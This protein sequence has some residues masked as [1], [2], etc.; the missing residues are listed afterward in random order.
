MVDLT[1]QQWNRLKP[2]LVFRF[3]FGV[4]SKDVYIPQSAVAND[5]LHP[6]YKFGFQNVIQVQF[7]HEAYQFVAQQN[8]YFSNTSNAAYLDQVMTYL[9]DFGDVKYRTL[10]G[11]YDNINYAMANKLVDEQNGLPAR[12]GGIFLN[13]KLVNIE[14][15]ESGKYLL[16]F[17]IN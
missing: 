13:H 16:T 6:L 11:G 10:V 14:K 9:I 2:V 12:N 4:D 5:Y 1:L 8:G 17:H 3:P 7:G 15:T